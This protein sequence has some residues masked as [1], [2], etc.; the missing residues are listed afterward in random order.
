MYNRDGNTTLV[1]TPGLP[2]NVSDVKV[3]NASNVDPRL[4]MPDQWQTLT[5]SAQDLSR[6]DACAVKIVMTASNPALS[7]VIDDFVI[8]VSE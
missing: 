4:I 5:F 6:F 2:D 8:T 1:R 3:R 7:P